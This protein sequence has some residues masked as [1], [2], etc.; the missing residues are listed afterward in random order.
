MQIAKFAHHNTFCVSLKL[1]L[2]GV[3]RVQVLPGKYLP[4]FNRFNP[5]DV[6]IFLHWVGNT[7]NFYLDAVACLVYKGNMLFHRGINGVFLKGSHRFSAAEHLPLTCM[8]HLHNMSARI[9]LVH[10]KSLCHA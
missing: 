2:R 4:I 5:F 1:R 8:K 3:T 6:M 9:T 10:L 7:A